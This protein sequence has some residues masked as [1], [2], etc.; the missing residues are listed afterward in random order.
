MLAGPGAVG[1]HIVVGDVDHRV[2][3]APAKRGAGP[4]RVAPARARDVLP[5]VSVVLEVDRPR[6][7]WERLTEHEEYEALTELRSNHLVPV[8]EPLVLISQIQ[9]S[10]GTLLS[11][12]FDGHPELHAHPSELKI[13]RPKFWHWPPL[14]LDRPDTWF[15]T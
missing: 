14:D 2:A 13:G 5:P 1:A 9:R 15:W 4:V 10:G 7:P 6:A 8:R 3:V 12:L 11:Q